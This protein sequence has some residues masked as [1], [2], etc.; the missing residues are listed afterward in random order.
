[1]TTP[2]APD[3]SCTHCKA[4]AEAALDKAGHPATVVA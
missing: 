3:K 4:T 2:S 1:M